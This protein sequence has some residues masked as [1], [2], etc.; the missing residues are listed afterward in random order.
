M[1]RTLAL[2]VLIAAT[3]HASDRPRG[4]FTEPATWNSTGQLAYATGSKLRDRTITLVPVDRDGAVATLDA[5]VVDHVEDDFEYHGV[6]NVDEQGAVTTRQIDMVNAANILVVTPQ[7]VRQ[8][9]AGVPEVTAPGHIEVSGDVLDVT[10]T[11]RLIGRPGDPP[12]LRVRT[13]T[14]SADG[15]IDL[16]TEA[17]FGAEGLPLSARTLGTIKAL[18]TVNVDL[19]LSRVPDKKAADEPATTAGGK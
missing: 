17:A 18:V 2:F 11:H 16:V 5:T 12:P 3:A 9:L 1:H 13:R 19:L 7:I 14:L 8:L 10:C 4:R 15:K 6:L